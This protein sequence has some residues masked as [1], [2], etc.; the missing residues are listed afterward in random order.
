MPLFTQGD[1]QD[2]Y[3]HATQME[4]SIRAYAKHRGISEGAV[5]KA[6]KTGR[7]STNANGKIDASKADAQWQQNSDL[8]QKLAITTNKSATIP[9][10]NYQPPPPTSNVGSTPSYQQ[11]RAIR[12]AYSAR[13]AKIN[14]ERESKKLIS[15]EQVKVDAY[16]TAR[17]TRDRI[18]NIP[19]RVIPML[20]G[21]TDIHEMKQILKT[22]L[23][24]ALDDLNKP[25]ERR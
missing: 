14:F 13:M 23:I 9:K 2:Q 3:T 25:Y 21:K 24:K 16:N 11:S 17:V 19:D 18:L 20:V 10:A 12:E 15:A 4:L 8:A 1:N 7:I 22:E 6:I 5:R